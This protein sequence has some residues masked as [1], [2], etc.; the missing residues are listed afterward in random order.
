MKDR[1]FYTT[2]L[3]L[4]TALLGVSMINSRGAPVVVETNLENLPRV[5]SGYTGTDDQF[6]DSVYQELNADQHVYRHYQNMSGEKVSLYIGYYGTQKG[7]RTGHNPYACL[8]GA[9]W[10]VLEAHPEVVLL[11]DV[12]MYEQDSYEINYILASKDGLYEVV[13][14]WYQSDKNKIL[15]TGIEQNIHRFYSRVRH[16][17]NDGAFI[18][19]SAVCAK[20]DIARCKERINRFVSHILLLLPDYWPVE[21]E[22]L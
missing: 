11:G 20:G 13:Y 17:R 18:R 2:A 10:G 4:L 7:G 8:P 3:I 9:G 19:L 14:H 6:P 22:V 16:N 21:R 15:A 5:I 12:T 1:S